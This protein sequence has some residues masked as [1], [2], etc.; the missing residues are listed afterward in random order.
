MSI[1][2]YTKVLVKL[3]R[4]FMVLGRGLNTSSGIP[5]AMTR[6]VPDPPVWW[7]KDGVATVF[8]LTP[9]KGSKSETAE[10]GANLWWASEADQLP[11]FSDPPV[12]AGT[13]TLDLSEP[14]I[15]GVLPVHGSNSDFWPV[16][17]QFP[18]ESV[19]FDW[20]VRA[21]RAAPGVPALPLTAATI[22]LV[23]R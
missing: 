23:F 17:F 13:N 15:T 14:G 3:Q 2:S 9:S 1:A 21:P 5:R 10:Y 12:A 6:R 8:R 20:T 16:T 18:S 7:Q 11:T 4:P 19:T 22:T